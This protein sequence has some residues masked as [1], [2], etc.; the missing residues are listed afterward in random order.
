MQNFIELPTSNE[1]EEKSKSFYQSKLAE[2]LKKKFEPKPFEETYKPVYWISFVTSYFCNLFSILTASTFVFSYLFSIF[3]KLPYPVIW[4]GLFS[5][6][7]LVLIEALQRI[8]APNLFKG[9]LQ[10]GF[11]ASSMVLVT[12]IVTLSGLSIFFSYNG[13]FDV[14]DKLTKAPTIEEPV[15]QDVE[16]IRQEYK[17]LINGA[18]NDAHEFKKA[19][20]WKGRLSD[21]NAK[22]YK[23][24]LDE[25]AN[26]QSQ[27]IDKINTT[28]ALNREAQTNAK[29]D[30]QKALESHLNSIQAKGGGLAKFTIIAQI[31]FFLSIFFMEFFDYKTASQ[32]AKNLIN[33]SKQTTA[34]NLPKVEN[35]SSNGLPVSRALMGF[36]SGHEKQGGNVLQQKGSSKTKTIFLKDKHTI[37]HKGK[38]YTLKDV[39]NF[40]NIYEKR[41]K[42]SM[43]K[44]KMDLAS[45]RKKTLLYWEGRKKELMEMK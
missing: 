45:S 7:L 35:G 40:I 6:I 9:V 8:L 2:R 21:R 34:F 42:E 11:K 27:M 3:T 33:D 14:V 31:G 28:E 43:K 1:F 18:S 12:I 29:E 41:V 4:A 32:Y 39:N 22:I 19:K 13:G 26:L 38:R 24:L 30:Y 15:L 5:G 44:G 10:Y 16:A 23:E 25:K 17:A 20:E 36:H 37:E